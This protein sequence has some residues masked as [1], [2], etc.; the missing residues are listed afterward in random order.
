M[1]QP[2]TLLNIHPSTWNEVL[3]LSN[4]SVFQYNNL[5]HFKHHV[6]QLTQKE[7]NKCGIS[8]A[9]ALSDLLSSKATLTSADYEIIKN[10]VKNNL[11]K[12]G[13][14]SDTIYESYS[15]QTEGNGTVDMAKL[16][17]QDPACILV[18]NKT[19]KKFFYELYISI[20]YPHHVS[21]E[22][23]MQNMAKILATIQL[24]EQENYFCKITLVM[25][26]E[27]CKNGSGNSNYLGLIPLFSH[28]D[29]KTIEYMSSVLNDRLLR[30][31]F[32]AIWEDLYDSS[33]VHG[34]GHAIELPNTIRP[35]DIDECDL[36]SSII[37]QVIVPCKKR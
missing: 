19:Y 29:H 4:T 23:I 14:I 33:L 27:G 35:V 2:S 12:R 13:L 32:F 10:R 30:K 8:Y 34:Y 25:P 37:D 20:S 7:D 17:A 36:A 6:S 18:P 9:D 11:L 3:D 1:I 31:F 24:L 15:Y 16:A 5:A 26:N 22:T 21:N 28:T